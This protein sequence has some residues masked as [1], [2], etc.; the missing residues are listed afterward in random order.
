MRLALV[1]AAVIIGL[2]GCHETYQQFCTE[3]R[4]DVTCFKAVDAYSSDVIKHYLHVPER[5]DCPFHFKALQHE[6]H[7]CSNPTAK[8]VGSDFD[9]YVRLEVF[10]EGQ[11]Y[12]RIQQDYKSG[13]PEALIERLSGLLAEALSLR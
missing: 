10:Y 2:S 11:C 9:G 4:H 8:A 5:E 6:I 13:S 7:S 1:S 12:Y 3:A